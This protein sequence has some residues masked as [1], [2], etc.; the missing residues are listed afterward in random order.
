MVPAKDEFAFI[1]VTFSYDILNT[2]VILSSI[3][4]VIRMK[5]CNEKKHHHFYYHIIVY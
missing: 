1:L 3:V 5:T 4:N 2:H